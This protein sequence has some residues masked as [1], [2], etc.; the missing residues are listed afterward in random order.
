[1]AR[2]VRPVFPGAVSQLRPGS[3]FRARGLVTNTKAAEGAAGRSEGRDVKGRA[4]AG[5]TGVSRLTVRFHDDE[6]IEGTADDFSLDS[7]DFHLEVAG[8]SN[9]SHALIPLAAV[10]KVNLEAGPADE[11]APK[12]E[13]MVALRF[14]DGE[15]LR[16]HLNGGLERRRFGL[17]LTLYSTDR[18]TMQ[19]VGVPYSSLK[20]IFHL[21]SWDGRPIAFQHEPQV[22]A[23]LVQ[24]MGDIREVTRM[25]RDGGINRAEYVQH[26]RRLLEHF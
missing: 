17:L 5:V 8:A 15:V 21:R 12:A 26:R 23:P 22:D 19:T 25:Y 14:Q 7:P 13:K 3:K 16:G 11:H 6:V 20:A 18:T 24:L 4:R 9:N 2:I 1:M 10:K